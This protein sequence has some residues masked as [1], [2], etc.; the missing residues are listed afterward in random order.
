MTGKP[1]AQA[2]G[3]IRQPDSGGLGFGQAGLPAL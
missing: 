2:I 1:N 3:L